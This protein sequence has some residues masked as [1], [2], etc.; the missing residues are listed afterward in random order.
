MIEDL[1][2]PVAP[3]SAMVW[4][5]LTLKEMFFKIHVGE[6]EGEAC[7]VMDSKL[8]FFVLSPSSLSTSSLL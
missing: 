5:C 3:T 4:P 1:P 7:K 8:Y 6:G 2:A